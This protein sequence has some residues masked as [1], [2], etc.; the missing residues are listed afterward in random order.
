[1]SVQGVPA[2]PGPP[3]PVPGAALSRAADDWPQFHYNAARSG[4]TAFP[5]PA[6]NTTIWSFRTGGAVNE[7][8][9]VADGV[10]YVP[11]AD[12]CL[13]ALNF[14]TGALI[15]KAASGGPYST[16]AAS[17]GLVFAGSE[18]GNLR[19]FRAADGT[20]Q[21][22]Y[23]SGAPVGT[24]VLVYGTGVFFGN[25]AGN[26]TALDV[27]GAHIWT[28]VTSLAAIGGL[29]TDGSNIFACGQNALS[30]HS[31]AD[32][33]RSW[34]ATA[35]AGNLSHPVFHNNRVIVGSDDGRLRAFDAAAG[36]S[37][38]STNLGGA[39]AGAPACSGGSLYIG[40]AAGRIHTVNAG[41]G[42]ETNASVGTPVASSVALAAGALVV[43]TSSGVLSTAT[44][45][46]GLWRLDIEGG[47]ASSPAVTNGRAFLGTA[48]GSVLAFGFRHTSDITSSTPPSA[49]QGTVLAFNGTSPDCTPI[50]YE[51]RS[52][53]DGLL[54]MKASFNISTL[55]LGHHTVS[56]R[57]QDSNFTWSAPDAVTVEVTP[58]EDWPMFCKDTSHR[59]SSQGEAP[60]AGTL[61]WKTAVGGKVY[62]SPAV[63]NGM[64]F[65]TSR[66]VDSP[67][68]YGALN[69][70]DAVTGEVRWTYRDTTAYMDSSPVCADGMVFVGDDGGSLM[71]F[72]A[73]P[74]DGIDEGIQDIGGTE[75]DLIWFYRNTSVQGSPVVAAGKVIVPFKTSA[76]VY[77]LDEFTG[78]LLWRFSLP[79]PN[80]SSIYSS[81]AV[82]GGLVMFGSNNRRLYALDIETGAEAWNFSTKGKVQGSPCVHGGTVYFGSEDWKLYALNLQNGTKRW[83]RNT[84]GEITSTP[85]Y[86]NGKL[87]F[88]TLNGTFF[89]LDA[90]TG[91]PIWTYDINDNIEIHSSAAVG[92]G[93]VV[94]GAYDGNVYALKETSL[95]EVWKADVEPAMTG[96]LV[97]SSPALVDGRVYVGTEGGN[98]VAFG[99]APDLDVPGNEI[100]F[101]AANPPVGQ[102]V[103]VTARIYNR[104]TLNASA[105]ARMSDGLPGIEIAAGRIDVAT[106]QYVEFSGNWTVQ[107]GVHAIVVNVSNTTPREVTLHNNQASRLYTPPARQGWTM[108]KGDAARTAGRDNLT[109]PN[110]NALDWSSPTGPGAFASPVTAG[111]RLYQASGNRVFAIDARGGAPLWTFDAGSPVHSTPAVSN[112]LV[113]GTLDGRIIALNE[114]DGSFMWTLQ[115]GGEVRS[116]PLIVSETVCVGSSDGYL[117]ALRLSSYLTGSVLWKAYLGGPV[118]SSPAYD[119]ASDTLVVGS[120]YGAGGGRLYCLRLSDGSEVWNL[121]A[122]ARVVSTPALHGGLALAGCDDGFLYALDLVEDGI[123]DGIPDP[124]NSTTDL[125]WTANLTG[126]VAGD[127]IRVRSSPAVDAGLAFVVAG[128][129]R[130]AAVNLTNGQVAWHRA[131]G[132]PA[133]VSFV[134]SSPAAAEGRLFVG[135]GALYALNARTGDTVWSYAPGDRFWASPAI[136][137]DSRAP[138]RGVV[139]A[140][141]EGGGLLAFS[142]SVKIP[143][144]AV[145]TSPEDG[146]TFRVGEP[147]VFDGRASH[148][149]DGDITAWNWSLGEGNFSSEPVFT[150]SYEAAGS[151]NISLSVRDDKGLEG[152]TFVEITVR[153][154]TAPRL[155]AP[156]VDP[157]D[158]DVNTLFRLK[159][160]YYDADNDP[161]RNL[162]A[163]A[164]GAL[165][166]LAESDPDDQNTADGKDFYCETVLPSGIYPVRFEASDG[167]LSSRSNDTGNLTVTNRAVFRYQGFLELE[168]FFAG[169]GGVEF[170][171]SRQHDPQPPLVKPA[172]ESEIN[173][174]ESN[175]DRWWWANITYNYTDANLKGIN[176]STL[177]L[178]WYDPVTR[179]FTLAE[180]AG[181]DMARNI[182]YANVTRLGSLALIGHPPVN[183]APVA[184]LGRDITI[185]EG[186]TV[187][188]NGNASYDPDG[189][190]LVKYLWDYGEGSN[191]TPVPG[192]Q[193]VEHRYAKAGRYTVTLI[194]NDGNA[195]STAATLTVTVKQRGGEQYVLI[196]VV[197]VVLVVGILFF[198]P[199][200]DRKPADR[201]KEEDER[202]RKGMEE[203]KAPARK[204]SRR[205]GGEEE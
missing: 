15:W 119:A 120:H 22:S 60:Q 70:L 205:G 164:A 142:S 24:P 196:L 112:I 75:R 54:S 192:A 21:F 138:F 43:G 167:V 159:V 166:P 186:E 87:F 94:F 178:Y 171:P 95:R 161:A 153:N 27:T 47:A 86:A 170:T 152:R 165:V 44:D 202:F 130:L 89:A 62:S 34:A 106:G 204:G 190:A 55:T 195:N 136:S 9:V 108:F 78:S 183:R 173:V 5:A 97:K 84:Y 150:R 45:G 99:K 154:N 49:S 59:G 32:G 158:G 37:R 194:V 52:D 181:I 39:I 131:L 3:E 199:R 133:A 129:N 91:D 200:G 13:Y 14:S 177:R 46:T 149:P 125:V 122:P 56:F 31:I 123:D 40:T 127:D 82:D 38:W 41:N 201:W 110:T 179:N 168:L 137:A 132:D 188:L 193:K 147:I 79:D 111:N 135:A 48:S 105:D 189:D 143:P 134:V 25:G 184:R 83:E 16:P 121:T 50:A 117:Y 182:T 30:A 157:L 67:R 51:W 93:L 100:N 42:S 151:Y 185:W 81:P 71:A 61:V 11:S 6:E 2:L 28:N 126:L 162:S 23:Q 33:R 96:D 26:L 174:S 187:A 113:F 172:G 36:F 10:V 80:N 64:V 169:R 176:V 115:T 163:V 146:R 20:P 124:E 77:A 8:P 12:G 141:S 102:N 73:D 175:I 18:D 74:S 160:T 92:G 76:S 88:G 198:L 144:A 101:S 98:V 57:I 180:N 66:E 85:A 69:A 139:Y 1:M 53:Q 156:S 4:A 114:W 191:R 72:D 63:Y 7:S 116:S 109:V 104:G 19:A 148:D 203:R 90:E 145:I 140:V 103:T 128:S 58:S 29:A 65:V 68:V 35:G 118:L 107:P 155:E 17:A 197:I